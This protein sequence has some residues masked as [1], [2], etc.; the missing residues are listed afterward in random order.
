MH[1][2]HVI[3]ICCLLGSAGLVACAEPGEPPADLDLDEARAARSLAWEIPENIVQPVSET[4]LHGISI[5]DGECS[6]PP[7]IVDVTVDTGADTVLLLNSYAAVTWRL[8]VAPG[9]TLRK[10]IVR[11]FG[12]STVLNAG[13]ATVDARTWG[14][15][16]TAKG[17]SATQLRYLVEAMTQLR[18]SSLQ[19]A[20]QQWSF[21]VGP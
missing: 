3:S 20:Y 21:T 12:P 16:A 8:V 13:A 18:M 19:L 6:T 1:K 11:G 14:M 7:C 2:L 5:R 4:K 9:S 15:Y 10:V 17:T